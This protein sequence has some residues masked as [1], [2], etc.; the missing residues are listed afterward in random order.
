MLSKLFTSFVILFFLISVNA[1]EILSHEKDVP[2]KENYNSEEITFKTKDKKDSISLSGT[3]LTPK[4]PFDKVVVI[5][6][7]SG[8]DTRNSHYLLTEQLLKNNIAVYRYDERGMGKSGGTFNNANYTISMMTDELLSCLESLRKNK[9]IAGKKVGL[10]GHSQGGMV[11]MGAYEKNAK[12][13]FMVQWATPVQKHGEFLKYQLASG[14]N[15]FDDVL[16]FDDVNRKLEIMTAYHKIVEANKDMD[17]WPLSKLLNKEAKRLK[18]TDANYDRFPYLTLSSEKDIVRKNF[19]VAYKSTDVPTLYVIGTK[20]TFVDP[21]AETA[22]LES[23]GNKN[24]TIVK[25]DGLNHYLTA[26][27]L[28]ISTMYGIDTNAAATIVNWIKTQ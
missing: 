18:Y 12:P 27:A 21:A 15:K 17:G 26:G 22:L 10:I 20:D 6:P 28:D 23:F 19:E 3:L 11:T 7:G 25:M 1:Q 2:G 24:I 8:A 9:N 13:D 16:K 5:V 14:Q 4:V